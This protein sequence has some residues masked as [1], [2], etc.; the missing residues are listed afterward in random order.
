MRR[1]V[2]ITIL[3][4]ILIKLFDEQPWLVWRIP[5]NIRKSPM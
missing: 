4:Y 1:L 5:V 3:E 2:M